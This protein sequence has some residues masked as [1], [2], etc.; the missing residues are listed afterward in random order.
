MAT[1]EPELPA[2][3]QGGFPFKRLIEAEFYVV[4]LIYGERA[5][6]VTSPCVTEVYAATVR[7]LDHP[8]D[9]V[10]GAFRATHGCL[11]LE[12]RSLV[13]PQRRTILLR[14][15]SD[16]T[17]LVLS[18]GT[19]LP[20][21]VRLSSFFLSRFNPFPQD[22]IVFIKDAPTPKPLK[23]I[24]AYQA[25]TCERDSAKQQSCKDFSLWIYKWLF[26]TDMP[27]GLSDKL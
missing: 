3:D 24:L 22:V 13:Y 2:P 7:K 16:G 19:F 5:S 8:F 18:F 4:S 9:T 15:A 26:E 20:E 6:P 11:I 1:S 12:C 25:T 14:I 27:Q 23:G 17:A 21:M 10:Q